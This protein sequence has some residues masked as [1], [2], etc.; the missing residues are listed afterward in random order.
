[1][2]VLKIRGNIFSQCLALRDAELARTTI[3]A[4]HRWASS[5]RRCAL[6]PAAMRSATG[7]GTLQ[8]A[9]LRVN[10]GAPYFGGAGAGSG[11]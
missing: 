1:M 6:A 10:F 2:V 5:G 9:W 7:A 8:G 4:A 3:C 11:E